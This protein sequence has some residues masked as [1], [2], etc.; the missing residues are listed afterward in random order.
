MI[1][2][3]RKLFGKNKIRKKLIMYFILTTFLMTITSLYT[4]YNAHSLMA[5]MDTMFTSNVDL[6]ELNSNV[7]KVEQYL[8]SYLA[9]K[10]SDSLRNYIKYSNELKHSID[11]MQKDIFS[12]E[13][14]L[15]LKDIRSMIE[16]FLTETDAAVQAKRGRNVNEYIVHYN[17][18]S[19][20]FGYIN[21]YI[22]KLNNGQLQE[23]TARYLKVAGKL[24]ILQLLNI[25]I[26][27]GVVVFNIVLILWFSYKI[28]K[29]IIRLSKSADEISKGNFDVEQVVVDTHDEISVMS[30]AF[31]R[32]TSSIK[33]FINEIKEKAMLEGRLKEQEMQN[34]IM[35]NVLKEA[36]LQALQSQINPHFIFNTLNA[37]AQIAMLEGADKT[38][39]FIENVANLFRYNLRKLDKPVTLREEID[40]INTYIFILKSRFADRIEF[41][42]EIDEEIGEEIQCI[43][44]PCMIL[45]PLVENAFIHGISDLE[46]GGRIL[47]KV[48]K[49][50]D[51]VEI[52]IKDNGKGMEQENIKKV[53]MNL[54]SNKDDY[55]H[56]N[57]GHTTGIGLNNV[58]SRLQIFYNTV[59]VLDIR[60]TLGQGTELI[61][62][63]PIIQ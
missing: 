45:Q 7:N 61:I 56:S 20:L 40:N 33:Q 54:P 38:C 25:F 58:I 57:S 22:S 34:L 9:T 44:M 37:G 59:D 17:E 52:T 46:N 13:S 14:G 51:I 60:S 3:V 4:Y 27:V 19:K 32:M 26:I 30:E 28:T 39:V 6:N 29:P 21:L 23:N 12:S 11:K 8:E 55:R 1:Q 31:N 49:V 41:V 10:H 2:Y 18:A 5:K 35:K 24:N 15:L 63:I 42:Q 50:K 16:S 36:E 62:R 53:L 47:L 43:K 48:E